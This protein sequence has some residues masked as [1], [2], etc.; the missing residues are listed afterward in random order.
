[1]AE[2]SASI[3]DLTELVTELR[4][5]AAARAVLLKQ[6]RGQ[7]L[8]QA[9]EIRRVREDCDALRAAADRTKGAQWAIGVAWTALVAAPGLVALW[10]SR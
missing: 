6:I 9:D 3:A 4:I 7:L 8:T 10:V 5:E 2:L 1:V